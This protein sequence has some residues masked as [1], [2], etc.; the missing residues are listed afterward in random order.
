MQMNRFARFILQFVH[1]PKNMSGNVAL[2]RGLEWTG[3]GVRLRIPPFIALRDWRRFASPPIDIDVMRDR[4]NPG[5]EARPALI[6]GKRQP[7]FAEGL[8]RQ[9]RRVF[10]VAAQAA[11][12]RENLLIG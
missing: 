2:R 4:V 5:G 7:N 11:E 8:L 9:V 1:E 12:V 6:R 10:F 3:S